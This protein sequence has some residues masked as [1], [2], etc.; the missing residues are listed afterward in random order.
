[1]C[2]WL[3]LLLVDK[4]V[5]WYKK[6]EAKKVVTYIETL[7]ENDA[8]LKKGVFSKFSNILSK[9]SWLLELVAKLVITYLTTGSL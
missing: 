3:Y 9:Y 7:A 4:I 8:P 5:V 6:D 2:Y 1:M